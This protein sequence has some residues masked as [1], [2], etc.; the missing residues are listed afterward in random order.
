MRASRSTPLFVSFALVFA[1]AVG[2]RAGA[3]A[4]NV[5]ITGTPT[6]DEATFAAQSDAF[7]GVTARLERDHRRESVTSQRWSKHRL[8]LL[9][10]V[11]SLLSI[12]GLSVQR[13]GAA[14]HISRS[15]ASWCFLC[16]GRAPPFFQLSVV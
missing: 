16:G 15:L 11:T 4:S 12:L 6:T 10:V 8:M 2:A 9:A 14:H 13:A 5:R 3:Q 7:Q 1:V